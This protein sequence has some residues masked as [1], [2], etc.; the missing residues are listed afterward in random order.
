M[1]APASQLQVFCGIF[2]SESSQALLLMVTKELKATVNEVHAQ[3]RQRRIAGPSVADAVRGALLNFRTATQSQE[4]EETIRIEE[5]HNGFATLL[6]VM[7]YAYAKQLCDSVRVGIMMPSGG[8][9]MHQCYAALVDACD[10]T[11]MARTDDHA[12]R[13][14]AI[15]TVIRTVLQLYV[16]VD[17][18]SELPPLHMHEESSYVV[19]DVQPHDSASNIVVDTANDEPTPLDH[20][21]TVTEEDEIMDIDPRLVKL[22][23]IDNSVELFSVIMQSAPQKVAAI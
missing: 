13:Q 14:I 1:E 21:V 22:A 3:V 18:H 9:F 19:D 17:P 7:V 2:D 16:H 8:Q 4:Q 20:Q 10:P 6:R 11:W 5:R 23:G 12:S 15:M